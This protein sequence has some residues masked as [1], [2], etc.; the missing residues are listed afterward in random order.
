[1]FAN[2]V[3]PILNLNSITFKV[4]FTISEGIPFLAL[5]YVQKLNKKQ[6]KLKQTSAKKNSDNN[7]LY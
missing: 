3:T 4:V 7:F 1:M 5:F 2:F 6:T